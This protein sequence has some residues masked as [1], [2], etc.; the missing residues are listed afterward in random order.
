MPSLKEAKNMFTCQDLINQLTDMG[1]S[2]KD[3][4][5]ELGVTTMTVYRYSKQDKIRK[6]ILAKL[7][8]LYLK[9]KNPK[10]RDLEKFDTVDLVRALRA[11]GWN[12]EI[13]DNN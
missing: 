8:R 12:V 13:T 7:K 6:S 10:Y 3:I 1:Y 4:A 9:A 2:Q 5:S 11:R